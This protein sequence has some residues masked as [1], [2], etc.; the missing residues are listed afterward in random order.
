[1]NQKITIISLP[2]FIAFSSCIKG[3]DD[4]EKEL[5]YKDT[6]DFSPL[7]LVRDDIA[8]PTRWEQNHTSTVPEDLA[9]EVTEVELDKSSPLSDLYLQKTDLEKKPEFEIRT[10]HTYIPFLI[11]KPGAITLVVVHGTWGRFSEFCMENNDPTNKNNPKKESYRHIKKF[12]SMIATHI[13]KPLELISFGWSGNRSN[14]A[15]EDGAKFLAQ[16]LDRAYK[17]TDRIFIGHS[18]GNNLINVATQHESMKNNPAKLLIYFACPQRLEEQYKPKYFEQLIYFTSFRDPVD[19]GGSIP[20]GL[21]Q[22]MALSLGSALGGYYAAPKLLGSAL[23]QTPTLANL[24]QATGRI[25]LISFVTGLT[26]G[27]LLT[28]NKFKQDA[29]APQDGKIIIRINTTHNGKGPDH[30]SIFYN[31]IR[32]LP[33]IIDTLQNTYEPSYAASSSFNLDIQYKKDFLGNITDSTLNTITVKKPGK[34]EP[35]SFTKFVSEEALKLS[36]GYKSVQNLNPV[37]INT[38]VGKVATRLETVSREQSQSAAITEAHIRYKEI[39]RL[40]QAKNT[41]SVQFI[42]KINE[43]NN[44]SFQNSPSDDSSSEPT[45]NSIT[46]HSE[47]TPGI[48]D[49]GELAKDCMLEQNKDTV[50]QVLADLAQNPEKAS[51]EARLQYL[52]KSTK[53]EEARMALNELKQKLVSLNNYINNEIIQDVKQLPTKDKTLDDKVNETVDQYL[54]QFSYK[55]RKKRT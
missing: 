27:A 20:E 22:F 31:S 9:K 39:E 3:M 36:F 35:V 50:N 2:F 5:L 33:K 25:G 13:G 40:V 37:T 38:E 46:S 29:L 19:K 54:K 28:V 48:K 55:Y 23:S 51:F 15:R 7:E 30:S 49:M 6:R 44:S 21:P 10:K 1:M 12:G 34:I 11:K 45:L 24:S 32:H 52:R 26:K 42:K 53:A 8:F 41:E 16:Y 17:N 18:H 4:L 14:K 43:N 47:N